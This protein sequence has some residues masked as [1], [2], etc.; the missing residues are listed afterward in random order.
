MKKAIVKSMALIFL[1]AVC[2][3]GCNQKEKLP[4]SFDEAVV[5]EEGEKLVDLFNKRDYQGIIDKGDANLKEKNTVEQFEESC[6]PI[7][8]VKGAFQEISDVDI[9]GNEDKATG[10]RY[11][12]AIIEGT[13]ANG[14]IVFSIAFNEEMELVQFMIR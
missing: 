9:V 12:G 13:Y 14:E 11:G 5:R 10:T 1:G 2:L 3:T 4:D 8:D 7:L 6:D